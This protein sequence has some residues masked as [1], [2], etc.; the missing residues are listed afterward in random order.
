MNITIETAASDASAALWNCATASH[1]LTLAVAA[2]C[3]AAGEDFK[4]AGV[5]LANEWSKI[6]GNVDDSQAT[7]KLVEA[8]YATTMTRKDASKFLNAVGLVTKQRIAQLLAV[9]Y[10]G[11]ASKN[12]GKDKAKSQDETGDQKEG[13]GYTFEQVLASLKTLGTMTEAQANA[14]LEV[15]SG[16]VA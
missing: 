9:V 6:G 14:M 3:Q 13:T 2:L 7:R 8:C 16:L 12:R 11:D 1:S 10:D 15:I 4:A 5:A